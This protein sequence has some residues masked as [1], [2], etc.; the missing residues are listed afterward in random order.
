M[1]WLRHFFALLFILLPVPPSYASGPVSIPSQDGKL[2]IPGY[3]FDAGGK[4]PQPVVIGLH[5]CG[6]GLDSKGNF[7][8]RLFRYGGYFNAERMH[9]LALDS[10]TPRGQKSICEIPNRLRTINESDR[11][12]DVFAAI[13]WLVKQPSVDASRI[14]VL[15]WSHGAQTVLRTIDATDKY[16]Q[17]QKVQP[18]AAVAF[19]PGCLLSNKMWSYEVHMPLL[20]MSGELDDWTPARECVSLQQRL[21]KDKANAPVDLVVYPGSYHGFDGP[22]PVRQ[23][24]GLGNTKT[25]KAMV[26]GNPAARE[27]S[28]ARMFE[29]LSAQLGQPLLLSHAQRFKGH[30]YEVPPASGFAAVDDTAAVPLSDAG[31]ARYAHFRTLPNPKA[32]AVTEKGGWYFN[33][34]EPEAMATTF[35]LCAKAKSRCWLYAVDDQVVWQVDVTAR[36]GEGGLRRVGAASQ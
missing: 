6:G 9:F 18:R 23:M 29:F 26:G 35:R 7:A 21:Q 20:I 28:H 33:A 25:G 17:A 16:V 34:G 31:K 3:W 24:E 19:Y 22:G 5:G 14:V 15:G 12:E 4:S 10:F 36:A 30:H 27:A 8:D 13:D 1:T 11:R 2:Q 32:F